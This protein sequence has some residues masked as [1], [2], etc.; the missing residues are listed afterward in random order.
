MHAIL[1]K[2]VRGGVRCIRQKGVKALKSERK[3]EKGK[4]ICGKPEKDVSQK[5]EK[6][7]FNPCGTSIL[8]KVS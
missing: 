2:L 5:P 1:V 3:P 6:A 8:G 7:I 4:K